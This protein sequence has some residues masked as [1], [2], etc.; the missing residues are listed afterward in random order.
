MT[1]VPAGRAL[2]VT[3]PLTGWVACQNVPETGC[4]TADPSTFQAVVLAVLPGCTVQVPDCVAVTDDP[5][6]PD[7]WSWAMTPPATSS[8]RRTKT[9]QAPGEM[10]GRVIMEESYSKKEA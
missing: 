10:R 9:P 8:A 4:V 2:T 6:P 3:V 1:A 5:G 7:C